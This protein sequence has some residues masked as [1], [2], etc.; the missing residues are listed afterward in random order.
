MAFDQEELQRRRQQRQ[1]ESAARKAKQR[2][3]LIR[4]AIIAAAVMLVAAVT[5]VIILACVD[6]SSLFVLFHKLAFTN[7]LW[8]LDP[9][10]DLLIR[11]MPL[12]FFISYAAI[13]GCC[14]LLGMVGLL[15]YT[16]FRI[17]ITEG[18]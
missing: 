17:K 1:K 9:Q 10:T 8:L 3:M 2:K 6:F 14:W 15:I 13:I 12:E 4:L 18:E 16:I 7:D 5:I 11:L